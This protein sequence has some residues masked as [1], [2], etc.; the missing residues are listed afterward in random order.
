MR[1]QGLFE[2]VADGAAVAETGAAGD[3]VQ[4]RAQQVGGGRGDGVAVS[5]AQALE[6]VDS[7]APVKS[8]KCSW[9]GIRLRSPGLAARNAVISSG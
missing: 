5:R 6:V 4:V 2:Q 7:S 9:I 1:G 8:P 3:P